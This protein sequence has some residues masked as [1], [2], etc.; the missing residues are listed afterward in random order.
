[1]NSIGKWIAWLSH[2][3]SFIALVAMMFLILIEVGLRLF[4]GRSTL[5]AHEYSSYLLIFFV[6]VSLAQ[7]S[8]QNRHIKIIMITE[9]LSP[10]FQGILEIMM[11]SL[12]LLVI[13]YLFYWSLDM[14]VTAIQ[15]YERAETVAG[16]PLAIPKAFIPIGSFMLALQ[17]IVLLSEKIKK[18]GAPALKGVS[19]EEIIGKS[20]QQL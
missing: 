17:L 20:G 7:V 1:M 3:G 9:R 18:I 5:V 15:N 6:F 12:T 16:T 8:K 13:I 4:W 14:T 11:L 19:G 2:K 10:K